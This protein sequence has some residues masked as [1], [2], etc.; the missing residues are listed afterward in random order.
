MARSCVYNNKN[1]PDSMMPAAHPDDAQPQRAGAPAELV[2]W[3]LRKSGPQWTAADEQAFEQWLAVDPGNRA[4]YAQW[5]ADWALMDAM[6]QESA[7]RL[8][9][10]VEADR[11]VERAVQR[12]KHSPSRRHALATGLA[13][14]G[15]AG[16]ALTGGWLG[17]QHWQA[18]PVYEQAFSTGRGQQSELTLPDGSTLRLD[19]ATSLKVTYFRQRREVQLIE[20]Q[21]VFSVQPNTDRPFR[22]MAQA[23]EVTVVGTRFSVRLTPGVP[24]R[25]GVEV[26]VEQGH[27]RVLRTEGGSQLQAA[28]EAPTTFNLTAGQRLVFGAQDGRAELGQVA[29]EGFASW[30]NPQ[31]SFSDVPLK[32][33]VA[34]M[35]RY[36]NLGISSVDPAVA[37]LRLTGTFN[38]RD[39]AATRRLLTGALPVKL[40]P[41]AGGFEIV[42]DR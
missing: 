23:V 26:A 7:N 9:A 21:A 18:Q 3:F 16:M 34:E 5:E 12:A 22:V 41:G 4:A 17:W 24:G 30:R 39:A 33:A 37:E 28:A 8:R 35:E 19:T 2:A 42:P 20:G 1:A 14:A 13:V 27:V 15:V 25:D 31:L 29:A 36:A 38:P 32:A 40:R 6:P 10:M 11:S